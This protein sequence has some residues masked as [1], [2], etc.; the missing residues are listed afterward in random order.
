MHCK[1]CEILIEKNIRKI[2]GVTK[3]SANFRRGVAEVEYQGEQ[4]AYVLLEE[5]IR[6]S[7]YTI[8]KKNQERKFFSRNPIDYQEFIISAGVIFI[9]YV[10]LTLSGVFNTG[11]SFNTSPTLGVVFLI[12]LAAG[13]STCMALV[14][15][16]ILG[17][18]ARHAELHPEATRLERF[19]PHL[20]FNLGRI[21]SYAFFGGVIG[22]LGSAL[23]LSN[24]LLGVLV[25]LA[26]FLMVFI[27]LKLT[28]L[29]TGIENV[30]IHMPKSIARLVGI[31]Q[32]SKE[33]SH[34]GAFLTGAL[35]FFLPC[36]FTQ[37]MQLYA[38]ST[39]SFIQGATIMALFALG[40]APGLLGLG[41]VS[42]V[43]KGYWSRFFFKAVA[44]V[45]IVLGI[46]NVQSGLN[47][48]GWNI[49]FASPQTTNQAEV[50]NGKQVIRMDQYG[51]GYS[52]NEFTVKKGIP[53][54]WEI[55]SRAQF[56]CASYLISRALRISQMLKP[57]LN[58]IEFTPSETGVIRFSCSMGMY[59]GI[60]NVVD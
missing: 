31:D 5:A 37:A 58:V 35:T 30:E 27:G 25:I 28:N 55:T 18:S 48:T 8:G 11:F 6:N 20:F 9:L 22:L 41:G 46:F 52:P 12:G 45:V 42:S 54:R 59:S 10:I 34:R 29:F 3:V 2:K 4:S 49:S 39:G 57:G 17:M 24:T 1:S 33:Y 38:V 36:G 50:V 51:N 7:G 53:V 15:G 56:T 44:V 32:D 60:I 14:G 47:L 23:A 43:V 21:I 16:L 19:R 40:T 26:G 13:V